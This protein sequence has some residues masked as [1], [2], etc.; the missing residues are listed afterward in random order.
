MKWQHPFSAIV[1]GPSG[2]GKSFFVKRFLKNSGKMIDTNFE[3][4]W[5]YYSNVKILIL[6]SEL[7]IKF[8]EG[9]PQVSVFSNDKN[10]KSIILD[11]L[12]R[13][14]SDKS[15]VDIFIKY[16]HNKNLSVIYLTQNLFHQVRDQRDIS[17][18]A[19][20]L[21]YIVVFK[22]PR[23]RSQI[24]YFAR[25]LYP[26]DSKFIQEANQDATKNPHDYLLIDLK[27]ETPEACRVRS[28]IFPDDEINYVY[29]PLSIKRDYERAN[30]SVAHL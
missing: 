25:Q 7:L 11:D 13:E 28:C 26:E 22:N 23:D 10:P 16:S 4:I 30:L 12:M 21:N 14:A 19:I 3:R 29:V 9:L 2:S 1:A 18:N 5:F 8:H 20:S 17:F 27:Q 15:A 24:R 6:K